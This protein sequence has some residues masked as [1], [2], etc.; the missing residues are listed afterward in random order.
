MVD[1]EFDDWAN[2][3]V[4]GHEHAT[5]PWLYYHKF[6]KKILADLVGGKPSEVVAMNQLTVNL[7]LMMVSFYQPTS[8]RYKILTEAGA[9][10]SDQYAFESQ[11]KFHGLNPEKTLIEL[12]PREEEFT[13]RTEDIL[14]AIET[15]GR[16]LALIIFGGVQYYTGQFFNIKKITEA[17]HKAGAIVGFDLAHAVGN[18]DLNL[19]KHNVDF[20]VWCSYKY[21]NSGPGG[22]AGA[23]IHE[24][25]FNHGDLPRFAGWWGH[26]ERER[27][28]M[29]KGFKPMPG[30]DGWQVSNVPILQAAA[31]LA[32]LEIFHSAT[33]KA[34]REKSILLTGY[35][36]FLLKEI[37]PLAKFLCY[38]HS[39]ESKR[40]LKQ[41]GVTWTRAY[42]A[43]VMNLHAD[44][45]QALVTLFH[46]QLDIGFAGNR[47]RS[48]NEAREAIAAALQATQSL[49]EDRIIR[50]VLNLVDAALRTNAFQRDGAGHRRPA[51]A[52]KF[53]SGKIDGMPEPRPYREIFVYSPRV[54]GL[55][56]RFGAIARGGLRWS[57]RP[58]DFRTEV[59]G[60][61]K[62][63][64]VKNAIIVPVGAKGAF[65]PRMMPKGADRETV[66]A[67]GTACYKIF[68]QT[69]LD[70]TDNLEGDVVIPPP[71]VRRRDGD[72]PYLVVA[73]DKGTA[74]FSDTANAIAHRARLLARRRLRLGRLQRLR[75]QEDGHHRPRRVGGGEAALPRD[76]PRHPDRRR[77]PWP[78]SAT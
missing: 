63:Q 51:L 44:V 17:G 38:H 25:H 35:L 58:E 21:L 71:D 18:V 69:L 67:E 65:V 48:A 41:I 75:P 31:H 6:S 1:Q 30:V 62:A 15:H 78:A 60:L 34:L 24:T 11:I 49:D 8:E 53:D 45:A 19:H 55:H 26:D 39:I 40:Y 5:H 54:E 64:Q 22:I 37:D 23:F 56:L 43:Q 47:D 9:F 13:L 50:R 14:N 33:I 61:V 74:T 29:K 7:H 52:I 3:G 42:L 70:V 66:Q 59:L 28:E 16:E 32:S 73:A 46:A 4:E 76:R 72:D 27:F 77:S 20:A 36:E 12:K 57:D 68:V 10:S 2:Q